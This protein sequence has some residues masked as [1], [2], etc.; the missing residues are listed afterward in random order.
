MESHITPN[1]FY[2]DCPPDRII[3]IE[4]EYSL[5]QGRSSSRELM[6]ISRYMTAKAIAQAGLYNFNQ[7][8]Y[9]DNG[10]GIYIEVGD[11]LEYDTPECLG[12]Q[13]AAAADLAGAVIVSRIVEASGLPHK[14]LF[15]L[16]GSNTKVYGD[17]KT[18]GYHENYL[19]PR[20]AS[21]SY[22]IDEMLPA[23]AASCI[24]GLSGM[25]R[26]NYVF[27]QK[28]WGIGGAPIS[29]F[30]DG[31]RTGNQKPMFI[32]PPVEADEDTIGHRAW[33]RVERRYAD[34]GFSP[35][36]RFMQ[37]ATMSLVLRMIEH[38]DKIGTRRL[39]QISLKDP[40]RAA[41]IFAADLALNK[42][43]LTNDGKKVTA[44][45]IQEKFIEMA[46]SLSSKIKLPEDEVRAIYLWEKI[47]DG[48]GSSRPDKAEYGNLI[49]ILDV[50]AR[51]VVLALKLGRNSI[52]NANPHAVGFSLVWDRLL[53]SGAAQKWWEKFPSESVPQKLIDDMLSGTRLPRTRAAIRI[54]QI[55][56]NSVNIASVN[57]ARICYKDNSVK[58]LDD[59]YATS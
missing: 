45:D 56:N 55:K 51:H 48:F 41:H 4:C 22:L 2:G 16:S 20:S 14:G 29:R 8:K 15:R 10:G 59:F 52:T 12:P 40:V 9:L 47:V 58:I 6:P 3:G 54:E 28:V 5:Q 46:V 34:A 26:A 17:G 49:K 30:T 21:E 33:A 1:N 35:E 7:A 19:L 42:T 18:S 50:S 43:V 11:H 27:S 13:E 32:I 37:F 25:V 44:Q 39:E 36:V 53:P 24:W 23:Y 57:W 38:A 31:R